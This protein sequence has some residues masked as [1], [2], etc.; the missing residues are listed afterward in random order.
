MYFRLRLLNILL[1]SEIGVVLENIEKLCKLIK[2][3]EVNKKN[4][5]SKKTILTLEKLLTSGGKK[6][7]R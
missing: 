3:V 6:L 7:I 2:Q 5:V 4:I 1:F